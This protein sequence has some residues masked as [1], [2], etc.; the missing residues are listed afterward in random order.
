[1]PLAA[2]HPAQRRARA[3][4]DDQPLAADLEALAVAARRPPPVTRLAVPSTSTARA[5]SHGLAPRP[6]SATSGS[7]RRAPCAAP[8]CRGRA[9]TPPGHGSCSSAP[10]PAARSPRL[11]PCAR[12]PSRRGRAGR[13]SAIARGVRPSPQVLSRG[14]DGGVGEDDVAPGPGRPGRGRRAGGAGADDEHVGARGRLGQGHPGHS[15]KRHPADHRRATH[16]QSPG[17]LCSS[18]ASSIAGVVVG[19]GSSSRSSRRPRRSPPRRRTASAHCRA[20]RGPRRTRSRGR[21]VRSVLSTSTLSGRFSGS[22]RS[23]RS[24]RTCSWS[25]CSFSAASSFSSCSSSAGSRS[26]ISSSDR[27][28]PTV[29]TTPTG[30]FAGCSRTEGVRRRWLEGLVR[31]ALTGRYRQSL[32]CRVGDGVCCGC[33]LRRRHAAFYA[34]CRQHPARTGPPTPTLV[35]AGWVGEV[36]PGVRS[37]LG[38]AGGP[39]PGVLAR[40]VGRGRYWSGGCDVWSRVTSVVPRWS[41]RNW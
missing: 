7:G 41:R 35:L 4:G 15:S 32:S 28:P 29:S 21:S 30:G 1:M 16:A 2:Q 5:P 26:L 37:D 27:P 38:H 8:P 12:A 34:P 9:A 39:A 24:F 25:G 11:T 18:S 3:V 40:G 22:S 20:R 33:A 19:C 14:N 36:M 23:S 17:Q 31:P 13:S 6:S 10:N